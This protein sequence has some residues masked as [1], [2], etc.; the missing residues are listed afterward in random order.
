MGMKN[1]VIS[2][3]KLNSDEKNKL[4][5]LN[6]L[7]R[8]VRNFNDDAFKNYKDELVNLVKIKPGSEANMRVALLSIKPDL[9]MKATIN[10]KT[11]TEYGG[12]MEGVEKTAHEYEVSEWEPGVPY[13]RQWGESIL[14]EMISVARTHNIFKTFLKVAHELELM[15]SIHE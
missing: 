11:Y 1:K 14:A 3:P 12:P 7:K 5:E 13:C 2:E 4:N 15:E 9:T 6:E 8:K 10:N